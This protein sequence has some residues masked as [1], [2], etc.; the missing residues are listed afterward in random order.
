MR[1]A[2]GILVEFCQTKSDFRSPAKYIVPASIRSTAPAGEM[3]NRR[4]T[5]NFKKENSSPKSRK[6]YRPVKFFF[7]SSFDHLILE[8]LLFF[9]S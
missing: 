6:A 1:V 3:D 9:L 8:I 5:A 7:V 4:P 2:V